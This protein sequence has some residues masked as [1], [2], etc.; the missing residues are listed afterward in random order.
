MVKLIAEIDLAQYFV[1]G[2]SWLYETIKSL[3]RPVYKDNERLLFYLDVS[4]IYEYDD[5]QGEIA[6]CLDQYLHELDIPEYFVIK[7]FAP[8]KHVQ[9]HQDTRCIFPWMQLYFDP[10]G[11]QAPCCYS[12]GSFGNLSDHTTVNQAMNTPELKQLRTAMLANKKHRSCAMCYDLEKIGIVSERQHNTYNRFAKYSY[13]FDATNSDGSIDDVSVR[14]AVIGLDNI[15]NFKCR[16]CHNELSSRIESEDLK[17]GHLSTPLIKNRSHANFTAFMQDFQQQ[18]ANVE[19]LHFFGGEPLLMDQHYRMLDALLASGNRD[20]ELLYHSNLS[21]LS[22]KQANVLDYWNQF[23]HVIVMV[24][25]DAMDARA[26]YARHGSVWSQIV[27]N[28]KAVKQHAP[29][30]KLIVDTTFSIY[31]ALHVA[32][33]HQWL[34]QEK[35]F[36]P[37]EIEMHHARGDS[38]DPRMLPTELKQQAVARMQEFIT[39]LKGHKDPASL[40]KYYEDMTV[41][42]MSE[43]KMHLL[44]AFVERVQKIDAYRS[45]EFA[46]V[47]PELQ[48]IIDFRS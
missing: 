34:I 17:L 28:I 38:N 12:S 13:M 21:V 7:R 8:I 30:V 2:K 47:F 3:H 48:S 18:L 37:H 6:L 27:D 23:N 5:E 39:W 43:D 11:K 14:Y 4:D 29:R 45:E 35:L 36:E 33:F 46:T 42:L 15:C 31:N 19:K 44:P 32:D 22:H 25:L 40:I 26:A 20:L 10:L 41:L 16:I 9:S 24:S 1:L